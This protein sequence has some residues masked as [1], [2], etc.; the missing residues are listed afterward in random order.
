MHAAPPAHHHTA[1]PCAPRMRGFTLIEILV[2]LIIFSV[3]SVMGYQGLV[4]VTDYDRRT[5]AT[6]ATEHQLHRAGA[7]LLQD[8][9][10][11]RPRPVRDRLGGM[12]RA[13]DT[14]DT[15]YA[16]LFTRGGL[17][18]ALSDGGMQRLAYSVNSQ[19]ELLRWHWPT[20]D[21]FAEQTPHS[22]VL[23]EGVER[24][25][26]FQLN[27]RNEFEKNWPPLNEAHALDSLP[28][29]IRIEIDLLSGARFERLIPGV[30]PPQ[31][32]KRIPG[33][34]TQSN[35]DEDD[36]EEEDEDDE[37]EDDEDEADENAGA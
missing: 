26:F 7:I 24:V 23:L 5:R 27:A 2:A 10:H 4:A 19:N 1:H 6:Y 25:R 18:A 36:E 8:L 14:S 22:Q 34:S 32:P 31:Q 9:L 37:D 21:S 30:D 35:E 13:Y 20:L 17:P 28:R 33:N 16:L 3:L 12:Q 29:M 11:A 15:D